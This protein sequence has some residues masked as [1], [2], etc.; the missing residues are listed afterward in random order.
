MAI[1]S[2]Q[3]SVG[4]T[5]ELLSTTERD[6]RSGSAL[7]VQNTDATADLYIGAADVTTAT[8]FKVPAGTTVT[9]DVEPGESLYGIVASGTVDVHVLRTSV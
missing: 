3:I 8:G 1:A 4:T 6:S 9:L 5:A 7:A 2:A